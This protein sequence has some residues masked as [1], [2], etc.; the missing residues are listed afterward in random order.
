MKRKSGY[1]TVQSLKRRDKKDEQN[2]NAK[3]HSLIDLNS[4]LAY[5][6]SS[7]FVF[8]V[9]FIISIFTFMV[10]LRFFTKR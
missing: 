6:I 1:S 4:D 8:I 10:T 3:K 9:I 5:Q 2:I 7:L